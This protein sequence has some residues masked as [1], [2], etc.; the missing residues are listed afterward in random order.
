MRSSVVFGV[1]LGLLSVSACGSSR[2]SIPDGPVGQ[3]A[4]AEGGATR[5]D[6]GD[7]GGLPTELTEDPV[8]CDQAKATK[9]Y[10]GCDYWPTVT[11]NDPTQQ[12]RRGDP[13]ES[14]VAAVAQWRT[15]YLFLAPD[16]YD[17]SYVDITASD[18]AGLQLDGAPVSAPA[19]KIDGTA[20]AVYRVHLGGGTGGAHGLTAQKAVGIQVVGYGDNTSYEVPGGLNLKLIAPPPK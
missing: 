20:F 1:A 18:D 19:S 4:G 16:D 17:V 8:D 9:S 3:D 6:D 7:G 5:F 14:L 15:R 13:D 10:V 12:D 11:P 2:S